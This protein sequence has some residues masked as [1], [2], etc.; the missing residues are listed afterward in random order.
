MRSFELKANVMQVVK[1][2][3]AS[4]RFVDFSKDYLEGSRLDKDL[5]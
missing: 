4:Y 3:V 1:I 5:F 2:V